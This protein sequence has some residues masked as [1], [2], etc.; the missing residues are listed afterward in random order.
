M[1]RCP[2]TRRHSWLFLLL[3]LWIPVVDS[4]RQLQTI[5][6]GYVEVDFTFEARMF[7]NGNVALVTLD[8]AVTA[9]LQALAADSPVVIEKTESAV[10]GR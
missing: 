7:A 2:C 6:E 1:G 5:P 9:K 3:L 4:S 8:E 10:T